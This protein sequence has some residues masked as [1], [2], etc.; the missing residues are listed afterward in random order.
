MI[1]ADEKARAEL[2]V[3]QRPGAKAWITGEVKKQI[4]NS[5]HDAVD[6]KRAYIKA[7]IAEAEAMKLNAIPL[8]DILARLEELKAGMPDA[9]RFEQVDVPLPDVATLRT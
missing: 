1:K 4:V 3:D 6:K 8:D 5:N 7:A 2:R 9:L